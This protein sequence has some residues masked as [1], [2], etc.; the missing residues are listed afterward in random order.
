MKKFILLCAFAVISILAQA[1]NYEDVVY[2]KNGGIIRGMIIEQ[3]P[4]KSVKIQT[5]DQNVFV[6]EMEEVEKFT[7]EPVVQNAQ[8]SNKGLKAGYRGIVEPGMDLGVGDYSMDRF[9]FNVVNGYQFNP[10]F[11]AG[12]GTGF[13][14][15]FEADAVLLPVFADL[16]TNFIDNIV[17]PY[18]SLG[19][20]YSF[21]ATNNF[22]SVGFLLNPAMG[23]RFMISENAAMTVGLGYEMQRMKFNYNA[24]YPYY[25]YQFTENAGALSLI[26]SIQF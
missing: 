13:R 4:D 17:S 2:L 24:Y 25:S 10:Y 15:Y 18:L 8:S 23:V 14:Y 16:R 3:I 26:T 21:D 1:Q 11:S 20:G 5:R 22:E 19:I 9:K 7:K 6:F 12:I